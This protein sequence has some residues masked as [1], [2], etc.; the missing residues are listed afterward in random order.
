MLAAR[1]Q[2]NLFEPAPAVS[3]RELPVRFEILGDIPSKKNSKKIIQVKG[4]VM[5]VPSSHYEKWHKQAMKQI[6][7]NEPN[8]PDGLAIEICLHPSTYR[9]GDLSNKAESLL[10][11]LV[12]RGVIRD[13]NWFAVPRVTLNFGGVDRIN[14]RAEVVICRS[15]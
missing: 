9:A 15:T 3:T 13:D 7:W 5:I 10:D 14:P 8:L 1:P 2:P 6:E 11:L 12:D 4:R